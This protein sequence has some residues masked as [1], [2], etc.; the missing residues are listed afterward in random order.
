[1]ADINSIRN[2]SSYVGNPVLGGG[3]SQGAAISTTPFERLAAFTYYKDQN[4]WQQ[5]QIDDKAAAK[6]ISDMTAYDITSPL[7]GYNDYLKG[8]LTEIKDF[9]T[10]N[11]NALNYGKDPKG[12]E[13]FKSLQQEFLQ[14][15][16]AANQNDVIYNARKLAADKETTLDRKQLALDELEADA[17]DLFANGIDG[18]LNNTLNSVPL[19]RENDYSIPNVSAVTQEFVVKNSNDNDKYTLKTKDYGKVMANA[20]MAWV[21]ATQKTLDENSPAFKALSPKRQEQQR[22]RSEIA[23]IQMNAVANISTN[24]NNLLQQK[25]AIDPNF[26]PSEITGS[27]D[28]D[29]LLDAVRSINETNN[30]IREVNRLIKLGEV[31]DKSGITVKRLFPEINVDDGISP[32]DLIAAQAIAKD[33]GVLFSLE[34]S[35]QETD[36]D[37][38]KQQIATTRRGQDLDYKVAWHNATKQSGGGSTTTAAGGI[39][40][41]AILFGEHINRLKNYLNTPGRNT[42]TV[43][44]GGIDEKT[45]GALKIE[46][47][48]RVIYNKDGSFLIQE[49][50]SD[51]PKSWID[52]RVGT[53]EDLKQG[54]INVAKGG[55]GGD[56]TQTEG[57]QSESEKGFNSIFGTTSGSTIFNGW[58]KKESATAPGKNETP[59]ERAKRI[60]NE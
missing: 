5:K 12:F 15:R 10:A 7:K 13:K 27:P 48:Q 11:P 52:L 38:Q 34:K 18:A 9:V 29:T 24:I 54:Y 14:A 23:S 33:G 40:T 37:I 49:P 6:E 42:L 51:N 55:M 21:G 17:E 44:Y 28:G 45:R 39:T 22:K 32:A 31:K 3:Y 47:G 53:I 1:M 2:A 43:T 20:Q 58:G 26:K 56:G 41:P 59:E 4:L 50:S 46:E 8:K 35:V 30:Q 57:F 19:L 25:K 60:A 16:G 36:D